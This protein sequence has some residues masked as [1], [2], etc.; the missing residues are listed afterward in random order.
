MDEMK[1]VTEELEELCQSLLDEIPTV[2]KTAVSAKRARKLT[3]EI[4]RVGKEF[5]AASVKHY[6]K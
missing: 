2:G 6:K 3:S 1:K 4:T 5:R